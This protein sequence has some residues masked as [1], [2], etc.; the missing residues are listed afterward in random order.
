MDEKNIATIL[1]NYS[2]KFVMLPRDGNYKDIGAL[3]Y[4]WHVAFQRVNLVVIVEYIILLGDRAR[5]ATFESH[6]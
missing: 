4:S 3:R 2:L 6:R 5:F 1:A